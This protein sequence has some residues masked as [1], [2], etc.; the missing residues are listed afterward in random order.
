MEQNFKLIPF[1]LEKAKTPENPNGLDVVTRVGNDVRIICSN[2]RGE[3][4]TPII[5]LVQNYNESYHERC[6]TFY[7]NGHYRKFG[8][9]DI[10]LFLKEPIKAHRMTNQELAWWLGECPNEHRECK[11]KTGFIVSN[12]YEYDVD[13]AHCDCRDVLIRSNGGEWRE[14]LIEMEEEN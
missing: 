2:Y 11:A 6:F 9:D 8:N 13:K 4:N 3:L 10:D 5:G 12:A 14:P 1:C 7:D